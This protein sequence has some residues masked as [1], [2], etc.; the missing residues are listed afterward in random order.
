MP[1]TWLK[2]KMVD[3]YIN[4]LQNRSGHASYND[5]EKMNS[6]VAENLSIR[7]NVHG[8]NPWNSQSGDPG[9]NSRTPPNWL[10]IFR[11][12]SQSPRRMPFW[13]FISTFSNVSVRCHKCLCCLQEVARELT[14]SLTKGVPPLS[15]SIFKWFNER[16]SL[17]LSL[18]LSL[19]LTLSLS[20]SLSLALSLSLSLSLPLPPSTS[21][22]CMFLERDRLRCREN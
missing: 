12:I 9:F 22:G 20:L 1:E 17:S 4:S 6:W 14:W 7:N 16:I 11:G 19:S 2:N 10:W 8:F 18:F 3:D 5:C 15:L 13:N 21:T